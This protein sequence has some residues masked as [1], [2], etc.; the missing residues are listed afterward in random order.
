MY[1][2]QCSASIDEQWVEE[3]ET[4]EEVKAALKDHNDVVERII[5]GKEI[6]FPIL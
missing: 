2:L 5:Q 3:Y 1:Y 4:I 6:D